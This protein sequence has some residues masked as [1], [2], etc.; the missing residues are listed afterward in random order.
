MSVEYS[1]KAAEKHGRGGGSSQVF[2]AP[3]KIGLT[4]PM[5]MRGSKTRRKRD[6]DVGLPKENKREKGRPRAE[7]QLTQL[8]GGGVALIFQ[9]LTNER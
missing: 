3:L 2:G 9:G 7:F 1:L 6:D 8:G 5:Q 4:F